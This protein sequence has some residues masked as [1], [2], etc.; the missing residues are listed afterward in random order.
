MRYYPRRAQYHLSR[1]HHPSSRY[2]PWFSTMSPTLPPE[3]FDETIDHLWD[4]S[5]A[6]QAC[7]LTCRAW[8]PSSRL[9]LFRTVRLRNADDCTRFTALLTAVPSVGHYVRKLSLSAEYDG[10]DSEGGARENDGW[11]N[12][13]APLLTRLTG[14]SSLGIARVR[15]GALL[16]ETHAAF[17]A[18]FRTVRTLFLFEVKFSASRDVLDF[19]SAFPVLDEL[20]FQGVSWAHDS[21]PP[22]EDDSPSDLVPAVLMSQDRMQLTHL[23]LDPRSSP[24]LVT[25]WLLGHPSE[26]RLRTIQLCW[27][28]LDNTK[29]VRDLLHA[30]GASLETL[31]VEFPPGI[32]EDAVLQ[33]HLS[34]AHNTGLRS[35]HFGGLNVNTLHS[36]L[37]TR[38]FPWVTAMLAQI[39]STRLEEVSFALEIASVGDLRA[40]DWARIDAELSRDVFHGLAVLFYVSCAREAPEKDVRDEITRRL[41]GFQ[42]R[43]SL[44]ISCI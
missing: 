14:I 21:P 31:Q 12:A 18:L 25:E 24:T 35:L 16:P 17:F 42:Q 19:L 10:V 5:T 44:C 43:G 3:L 36:F 20:Y 29:P 32:A 34:L 33:D 7:S 8:L 13:A 11:V 40:L 27:H 4:D 38:L 37:S 2:P 41:A 39:R 28:D 22:L 6:L 30:S 23:F 26:Q 15:W 1:S 9:H